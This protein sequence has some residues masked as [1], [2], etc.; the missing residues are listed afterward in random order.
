[1]MTVS[2]VIEFV[3]L[4]RH[5]LRPSPG[6]GDTPWVD[7]ERPPICPACGVTMVPAAL[8]AQKERGKEWI[9][10]ECEERGEPDAGD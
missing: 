1:M 5:T 8:S 3:S 2:F 9:C 10:V 7:D 6:S 4:T